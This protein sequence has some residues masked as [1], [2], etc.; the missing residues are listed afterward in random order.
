MSLWERPSFPIR[1]PAT[2]EE[3]KLFGG[4]IPSTDLTVVVRSTADTHKVNTY[5]LPPWSPEFVG[6]EVAHEKNLIGVVGKRNS[7]SGLGIDYQKKLTLDE[8]ATL[9]ASIATTEELSSLISTVT[10]VSTLLAILLSAKE[11]AFKCLYPI[12]GSFFQLTCVE[13]TEIDLARHTLKLRLRK[14]LCPRLPAGQELT[15]HFAL[16]EH[17]VF[18]LIG[19][20]PDQ[21]TPEAAQET[22]QGA[23]I[24]PFRRVMQ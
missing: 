2:A 10:D 18:T 24:L 22:T 21:L 14:E 8:A 23:K 19:V 12:V 4:T 7:V 11:S 20:L 15:G 16:D 1:L 9:S 6:T 17:G 3:W 5:S 13:V